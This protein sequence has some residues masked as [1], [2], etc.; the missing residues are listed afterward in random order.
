MFSLQWGHLGLPQQSSYITYSSV[1]YINH[2]YLIIGSSCLMTTLIHLGR[3]KTGVALAGGWNHLGASWLTWLVGNT[4][5]QLVLKLGWQNNSIWHLHMWFYLCTP[6][7]ERTYLGSSSCGGLALRAS[8][9][10]KCAFVMT[11]PWKSASITSTILCW[12]R[13][14]QRSS[15][16]QK[17]GAYIYPTTRRAECQGHIIGEHFAPPLENTLGHKR[18]KS[19]EEIRKVS[20][21]NNQDTRKK[22]NNIRE[23]I[24]KQKTAENFSQG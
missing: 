12:M 22:E 21:V 13:Q 4:G 10:K 2:F 20:H 6:E 15:Q 24:F 7:Y 1:N 5:Y 18:W 23:A 11:S 19:M 14:S 16:L 8:V 17:D 9:L 3:L